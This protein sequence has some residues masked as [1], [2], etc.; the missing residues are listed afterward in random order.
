MKLDLK[1]MYL[2]RWFLFAFLVMETTLVF[3]TSYGTS[4]L[5]YLALGGTLLS[6]VAMLVVFLRQPRMSVFDVL[7]SSFMLLL[8]IFTVINGTN[9][10]DAIYRTFEMLLLVMAFRWFTDNRSLTL[11]IL[12]VLFSACVYA[13]L[14]NMLMSLDWLLVD[15]NTIDYFLLGGNYNQMGV[16]MMAAIATSLLCFRR[17]IWWK[18]NTFLVIIVSIVSLLLVGSMTSLTCITLFLLLILIPSVSIKKIVFNCYIAFVVAFHVFVVFEGRGIQ[19]NPYAVYF[20]E[21]VLHKDIT[22]THRTYMWD[23]SAHKVAESPLIG[24]GMVG[25]DWYLSEMSTVAIGSHNFIYAVLIYGGVT[26]F[27]LYIVICVMSLTR[28]YRANDRDSVMLL[29]AIATVMFM[30]A[31]EVYPLFH[32]FLFLSLAYYYKEWRNEAA[33][34]LPASKECTK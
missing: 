26:L 8:L 30:M 28:C 4:L 5:S 2:G 20:I 32:V 7:V 3:H 24:Y 22:F 11:S 23:A 27:L 34:G 25:R 15:K 29:L 13:N 14:A 17:N 16:R 1:K 33:L 9:L 12:A 19:N 31:F 10:A 18:I 21:Q 6:F